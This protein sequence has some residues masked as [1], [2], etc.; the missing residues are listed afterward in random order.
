MEIKYEGKDIA[1]DVTMISCV[2]DMYASSRIDTLRPSFEK[3]EKWE[4]WDPQTGDKIEIT[5]DPI[6]TG[7]MYVSGINP[8]E[9][10][11]LP[12]LPFSL[13]KLKV[14][15]RS[16]EKVKL[17]QLAKDIAESYGLSADYQAKAD[18][19]YTY[20]SQG[21]QDGLTWLGKRLML[22]GLIYVA[23]DG[24][25]IILD[26]TDIESADPSE[27]IEITG[28][29]SFWQYPLYGSAKVTC[30]IYEGSGSTGKGPEYS[31]V[32]GLNVGSG[33]EANRF[34]KGLL[35]AQNRTMIG[36]FAFISYKPGIAAGSVV[37]LDVPDNPSWDGPVFL[38]HVRHD[39]VLEKTK[40]FFRKPLSSLNDHIY[41]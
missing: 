23:F 35:S 36:G 33:A 37:E 18:P 27:T 34:A 40:I 2:H 12:C 8:G 24:K 20:C 15:G 4:E 17:S 9:T 16:W 32:L 19:T 29:R 7:S 21:A 25:L 41:K 30:G 5:S 22:E 11:T 3:S 6:N 38:H 13:Q 14:G 26:D 31:A 39:Y 28:E 1:D 10:F